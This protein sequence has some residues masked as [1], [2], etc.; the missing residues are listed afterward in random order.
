MKKKTKLLSIISTSLAGLALSLGALS[1]VRAN[2]KVE[3]KAYYSPSTHYEVS[4]TAS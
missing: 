3:T 1:S 2:E 4:D